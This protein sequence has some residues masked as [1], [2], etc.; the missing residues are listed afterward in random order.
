M[1]RLFEH[2]FSS[3]KA[4]VR[5]PREIVGIWFPISQCNHCRRASRPLIEL[6]ERYAYA[7]PTIALLPV[8]MV[9]FIEEILNL[10]CIAW[11]E[12]M[13]VPTDS[14]TVDGNFKFEVIEFAH[15]I[16]GLGVK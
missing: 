5:E 14:S 13:H 9:L 7:V 15:S 12:D 10:R 1:A 11:P 3:M 16:V 2:P 4:L 8:E 6:R